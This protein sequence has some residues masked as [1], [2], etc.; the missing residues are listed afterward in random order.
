MLVFEPES[1]AKFVVVFAFGIV[2]HWGLSVAEQRELEA[3][4]HPGMMGSFK[5]E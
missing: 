3:K 1:S 5:A 4:M 2:V